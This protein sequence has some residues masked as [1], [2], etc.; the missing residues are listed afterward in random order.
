M[1]NSDEPEAGKLLRHVPYNEGF[2]FFTD[3][4]KYTGETSNGLEAF[5]KDIMVIEEA[6]IRFHIQRGDFQKWIGNTIGDKVLAERL[7]RVDP[8]LPVDNLRKELV[9]VVQT[10][11][12]ELTHQ[13][14][15]HRQKHHHHL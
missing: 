13:L 11:I 9:K 1:I 7:G 6:S 14:L 5:A 8:Q 15:Q 4:G 10:R 3:I 2:H 12:V